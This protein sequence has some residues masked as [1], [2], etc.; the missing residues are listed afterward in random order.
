MSEIIAIPSI[1]G[2]ISGLGSIKGDLS[3]AGG[4]SGAISREL[5]HDYYT[6]DYDVTPRVESQTLGTADKIMTRD[7]VINDIPFS[8]TVNP[9]GGTTVIIAFEA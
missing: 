9:A 8:E 7:V 2:T 4:I 5:N 3:A 1:T 6:G